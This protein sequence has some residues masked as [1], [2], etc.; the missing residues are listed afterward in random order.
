MSDK[1][2]E[3]TDLQREAEELAQ[4]TR[5]ELK[6]LGRELR[7]RAETVRIEAVKQLHQAAETIRK[8][9]R[10]RASDELV[11]NNADRLAQ[12]L[13]RTAHYLNTHTVDQMGEDAASRVRKNPLRILSIVFIVGLFIGMF[14]RRND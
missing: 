9:A 1:N 12:G 8:E 13:E 6:E 11:H 7:K 14:L 10:E 4:R 5:E 2:G 3:V